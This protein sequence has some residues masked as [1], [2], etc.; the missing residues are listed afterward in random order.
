MNKT[1][2]P[3]ADYTV[4]PV[5]GLCPVACP[6]CYARRMYKRFKWDTA[7]RY[8][9]MVF[10]DLPNEPSRIFVGSTIDLFHPLTSIWNKD[11]FSICSRTPEHTFIFLTKQPQ[12]LHEFSPFPD[13]C[14]IGVSATD[15]KQFIEAHKWL[16]RINPKVKFISFEPLLEQIKPYDEWLLSVYLG[17]CADWII[18]GSQT[19]PTKHPQ[20]GWVTEIRNAAFTQGIPM[21]MKEPMANH[22]GFLEQEFPDQ[23]NSNQ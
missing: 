21:F 18:I 23:T 17:D 16:I 2:I 7:I 14:W 11:I 10:M 12:Y 9:P 4:N 22:Y 13:N 1:K 3:W 15:S 20:L 6:Y 5:K 19:Q 8:D